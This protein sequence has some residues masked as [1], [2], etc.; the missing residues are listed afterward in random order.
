M[1]HRVAAAEEYYD[2]RLNN[3]LFRA[4]ATAMH[5][6]LGSD[7]QTPALVLTEQTAGEALNFN[8]HLHGLL[9]DGM[10]GLSC[11]SMVTPWGFI[12]VKENLVTASNGSNALPLRSF[13]NHPALSRPLRGFPL[14]AA[15]NI[16]LLGASLKVHLTCADSRARRNSGNVCEFCPMRGSICWTFGVEQISAPAFAIARTPF[17]RQRKD[18]GTACSAA[19]LPNNCRAQCATRREAGVGRGSGWC[20]ALISDSRET[21]GPLP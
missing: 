1:E 8:P 10:F 15:N 16:H 4:A 5:S 18:D 21:A 12:P 6:V 2:R 9:A 11:V 7:I 3:I 20:G 14:G 17:E 13:K 19:R